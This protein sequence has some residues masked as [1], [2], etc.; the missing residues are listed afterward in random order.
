MLPRPSNGSNAWILTS[1]LELVSMRV[2][3]KPILR[4][5]NCGAVLVDHAQRRRTCFARRNHE[6]TKT[7]IRPRS[8]RSRSGGFVEATKLCSGKAN[9]DC[10]QRECQHHLAPKVQ[11]MYCSRVL[12]CCTFVSLPSGK[13]VRR[14]S[15]GG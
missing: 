1:A 13:I 6:W 15:S 5:L 4:H 7:F 9:C 14:A 8:H 10:E 2:Q 12:K 3:S 11:R